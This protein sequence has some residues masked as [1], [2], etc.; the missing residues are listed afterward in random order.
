MHLI[1]LKVA[2]KQH[3]LSDVLIGEIKKRLDKK[4]QVLIFLNR[5]GY[6]PVLICESCG[7]QANC[8]NCDAHFTLHLKPYQHLHCHHCGTINRLPDACPQCNQQQLKPIGMG[9]AKVEETLTELFP[10][11]PVLRVDRDST[12]RVGSWQ[13]IYDQIQKVNPRFCLGRKCSPK[14][15][16]SHMSLWL[17]S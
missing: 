7:W 4:E 5:R 11:F 17:Q 2:K 3:G 8:P 12:S 15:I 6:A 1:D 9:T 13:K 10:N 16:I 14:G